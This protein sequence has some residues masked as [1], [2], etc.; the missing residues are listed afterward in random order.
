MGTMQSD[1]ARSEMRT[2]TVGGSQLPLLDCLPEGDGQ[3]K[4]VVILHDASG[5]NEHDERET[6]RMAAAGYRAV[7]PHLYHRTGAARHNY[8]DVEGMVADMKA[9]NESDLLADLSAAVDYLG[10]EGFPPRSIALVGF[11]MG[12]T[13]AVLAARHMALGAAITYYGGGIATP[14]FPM[15]AL[16]ELAPEF[17]TPWL[18]LYG[19]LDHMAPVEEVE[20]LRAAAGRSAVPTDLRRYTEA[21]HAFHSDLRPAYHEASALDASARQMAWIDEHA[22]TA[23]T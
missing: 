14:Q 10:D 18:G 15:P 2:L 11:C 9:L 6:A 16:L 12:G 1:G 22:H 20:Q 21:D 23:P 7:L 3:G 5:A 13:I 19:D 8:S 17:Q 4:A